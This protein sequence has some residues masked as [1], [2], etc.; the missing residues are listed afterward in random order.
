[1][2]GIQRWLVSSLV[3]VALIGALLVLFTYTG[4]IS[5]P[6]GLFGAL[7]SNAYFGVY[8]ASAGDTGLHNIYVSP[9]AENSV[10][11]P[12]KTVEC[13]D[14]SC[15][16]YYS[17][18][19]LI[20]DGIT[21]IYFNKTNPIFVYKTNQFCVNASALVFSFV[22]LSGTIGTCRIYDRDGN[23]I[24]VGNAGD[25]FEIR[26]NEVAFAVICGD[27]ITT[28]VAFYSPVGAQVF[29]ETSQYYYIRDLA[30]TENSN[31]YMMR[32]YATIMKGSHPEL[33]NE[34]YQAAFESWTQPIP[35]FETNGCYLK[36]N[37][38]KVYPGQTLEVPKGDVIDVYARVH[39][40]GSAGKIV[41]QVWDAKPEI[42]K[43]LLLREVNIEA[44]QT[45]DLYL[46]T[47]TAEADMEI[48]YDVYYVTNYGERVF[49]DRVSTFYVITSELP[50]TT[51]TTT[52][53]VPQTTTTVTTITT[54]ISTTTTVTT[55]TT[56]ISPPPPKTPLTTDVF[57]TVLVAMILMGLY[58]GRGKSK[59]G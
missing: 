21:E 20:S 34:V 17:D 54:T 49:S 52:T 6:F 1:M 10:L 37:D 29:F 4:I 23:M 3:V 46:G 55:I 11:I 45:L 9:D 30:C 56:T 36:H 7:W 24:F 58:L 12:L 2:N 22:K 51:I 32:A 16:Y 15:V 31:P 53:T 27:N 38:L 57:V 41:I 14:S 26:E 40:N 59:G 44:G 25:T 42:N 13:P 43:Q 5:L 50:T 47:V 39:N 18:D 48:M 19:L 8:L 28:A 35:E 33:A